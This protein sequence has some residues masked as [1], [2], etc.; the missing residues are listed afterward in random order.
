MAIKLMKVNNSFNIYTQH[1]YIDNISDLDTIDDEY[2]CQMGDIA[3]LPDGAKYRRHSDDYS[4]NLWEYYTGGGSGS[5]LPEVDS[6]DNGKVLKVV[7]GE[8]DKG[9]QTMNYGQAYYTTILDTTTVT[10]VSDGT[11]N[12]YED[13]CSLASFSNGDAVRV[14]FDG[15]PY[16]LNA[17]VSRYGRKLGDSATNYLHYPFYINT[18]SYPDYATLYTKEAGEHSIK[19]EKKV[20]N[21]TQDFRDAA[22]TAIKYVKFMTSQLVGGTEV[23]CNYTRDQVWDMFE[24]E[25]PVIASTDGVLC[26]QGMKYLHPN[27]VQFRVLDFTSDNNT[28]VLKERIISVHRYD[29]PEFSYSENLYELTV[30]S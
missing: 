16:T 27:M 9:S 5:E 26:A 22:L 4:G 14:T 13:F 25:S 23:T 30:H 1:F 24:D 8:W 15:T 3:E 10:T 21:I 29:T 7:N 19:I 6:G 17:D 18:A 11:Y 28:P 20:I 12:K 2:K